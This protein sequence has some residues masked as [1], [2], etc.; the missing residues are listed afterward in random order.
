MPGATLADSERVVKAPVLGVVLPIGPGEAKVAP[1]RLLELRLATLVV[2]LTEN[3]AVPV[4][5]VD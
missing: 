1:L 2:L 5:R 3:G 4:A